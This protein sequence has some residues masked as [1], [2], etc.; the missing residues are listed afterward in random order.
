[1][2]DLRVDHAIEL[3]EDIEK[4]AAPFHIDYFFRENTSPED[5][6]TAACAL[7]WLCR[8]PRFAD[9]GLNI[10]QRIDTPMPEF[11]GYWGF[12]A[13]A[14]VLEITLLQSYWLFSPQNY[15]LREQ[16]DVVQ[17]PWVSAQMV[18]DRLRRLRT[19]PYDWSPQ[20]PDDYLVEQTS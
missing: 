12:D 1:M 20:G 15:S 5:C 9:I 10:R 13:G 4:N 16:E 2:H 6:S 14:A 3:L 17:H 19:L 18:A 7:G 11:E 8:D